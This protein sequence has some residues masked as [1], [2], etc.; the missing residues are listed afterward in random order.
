MYMTKGNK[1]KHITPFTLA[2]AGVLLWA[3][4]YILTD[5]SGGWAKVVV[6][7]FG[8]VSIVLLVV[9]FLLAGFLANRRILLWIIESIV[10][11]G[12]LAYGFVNN[13]V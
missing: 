9:H 7:T 5:R 2:F 3:P 13:L 8:V 4:Y 1:L 11:L 6:A 10:I 12:L